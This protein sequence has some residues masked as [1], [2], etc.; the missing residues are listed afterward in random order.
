MK[1]ENWIGVLLVISAFTL[2]I[3]AAIASQIILGK[4]LPDITIESPPSV[5]FLIFSPLIFLAGILT[6]LATAVGNQ[7]FALLEF[8]MGWSWIYAWQQTSHSLIPLTLAPLFSWSPF[9]HIIVLI[10]L[11][12]L[13]IYSF[14]YLSKRD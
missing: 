6:M 12:S 9:A 3:I 8:I 5:I 13:V 2:G 7:A 10:I 4:G 11:L 1:K 14:T